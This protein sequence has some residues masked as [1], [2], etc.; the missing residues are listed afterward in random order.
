MN[1]PRPASSTANLAT[2][3]LRA[4]A[5]ALFAVLILAGLV[6][7]AGAVDRGRVKVVNGTVVSDRNTLLRGA[8][9]QLIKGYVLPDSYWHY[10][11]ATLGLNAVRYDVK[12]NQIGRPIEEQLPALDLA[13]NR[14]AANNLYLMIFN[15]IE[16]GTYDLAQLQRFWSVVAPRYKNRTHVF[17]EMTNEP[18]RGSPYWGAPEQFTDKVL[19]D[20]KSIYVLMRNGAPKTHIV[21][22]TS[23][24]IW[25]DCA[26]WAALIK[27]MRKIDWSKASVGFHHY[28]GTHKISEA[29]LQCL[30]G[31]YPL[32]MTETN[33]W[34][35]PVRAVLRDALSTYEKLGISWFSLDGTGSAS[36]LENEILP[37]LNHDGYFWSPEN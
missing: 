18:V 17:Y 3:S 2:F 26:S 24:N 27:K 29:D 5:S 37:A 21:L 25:P 31:Q 7:T 12:T 8:R 10:L 9:M 11:N 4:I 16:P 33:Y 1:V 6:T 14:A 30:R 34:A 15:A 22:F 32:L 35:K 20:L 23:A 13:V 28:N 19:A 36:H